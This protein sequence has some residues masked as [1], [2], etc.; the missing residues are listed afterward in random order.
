MYS[1]HDDFGVHQ[2]LRSVAGSAKIP[3]REPCQDDPREGFQY[4]KSIRYRVYTLKS[5]V[6][7]QRDGHCNS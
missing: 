7:K 2:A 1:D 4:R 5:D 3:F 6:T